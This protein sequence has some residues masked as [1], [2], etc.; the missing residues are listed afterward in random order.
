MIEGEG[1]A[2]AVGELSRVLLARPL[3]LL[4]PAEGRV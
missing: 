2:A 1:R 3:L 4:P